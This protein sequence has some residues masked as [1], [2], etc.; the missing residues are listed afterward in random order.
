MSES[1]SSMSESSELVSTGAAVVVVSADSA[2]DEV[3]SPQ[4]A[5][6]IASTIIT[7]AS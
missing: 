5:A 2:V 3:S 1:L 7:H 4:A 6:I